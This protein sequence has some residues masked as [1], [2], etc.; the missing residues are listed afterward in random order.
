MDLLL[1]LDVGTTATKA[2]L[3]D[4]QGRVVAEASAGY[5][6]GLQYP[7]PGWVEQD[8]A[9]LW[10]AVTQAVRAVVAQAPAGGQVAA[11]SLSSQGG[12]T[13]PVDVDGR[14][15]RP[16]ISWLDTRASAAGE[17]AALGRRLGEERVYRSTGWWLPAG[18]PLHHLDWLRRHEPQTF[19]AAH[20]FLFVND[21]VLLRLTG[22]AVMDP[23]DAAMTMLYNLEAGDW[24]PG[25][26]AAAGGE[27]SQFS[28]V[29]PSGAPVGRLLPAVAAEMG[30]SPSVLVVNGAHDQYCA[31][32]GSG[33]INPGDAVLS[34]G[35]AWVMFLCADRLLLDPHQAF[36][37]APHVVAGRWGAISSLPAAGAAMEWYTQKVLLGPGQEEGERYAWLNAGAARA[38]AGSRGLL[39]IPLLSGAYAAMH[40]EH[41]AG[42]WVGLTLA[43]SKDDL[44]RSVMEGV[45]LE[46]R[47][48]AELSAGL[49]VPFSSLKMVGG[50]AKSPLWPQVVADVLGIPVR[51]P[52]ATEAAGRGAA[53]LAGLGAG[54]YRSAEQA[55]AEFGGE[56][57]ALEPNV[58]HAALYGA[59]YSAYLQALSGLQ[60]SLRTLA[61]WRS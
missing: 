54:L 3:C 50:A 26:L 36:H 4:L 2:L 57:A 41:A 48:L 31:A 46:V 23:S 8:P 53:I 9:E 29:H 14:P 49:G 19:A 33:V 42:A 5:P 15:L 20:R 55:V 27:R 47:R 10:Q 21:Y 28:P 45:A 61:H 58:T 11:L 24:D 32:L 22:E 30:L 35:T 34:C 44:S 25:L 39:F 52:R 17:G 60:D 43:H 40:G 18:L 16:A 7:H 38:Q 56:E 37:P 6:S 51:L 59:L 1:G 13:I 12:T